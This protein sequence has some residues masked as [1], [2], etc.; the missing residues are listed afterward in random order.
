MRYGTAC[1]ILF[2][3]ASAGVNG[4]QPARGSTGPGAPNAIEIQ[5]AVVDKS[6]EPVRGLTSSDFAVEIAGR[7]RPVTGV[8]FVEF[9]VGGGSPEDERLEVSSNQ[10]E[11]RE[12]ESRAVLLLV[13]DDS[14]GPVEGEAVF[15]RLAPAVTRLFPGE[16]V[17]VAALSGRVPGV[18]FT[19]DRSRLVEALQRL[20]GG[21]AARASG[22]NL[23]VS[24][25]LEITRPTSDGRMLNE[26]VN[27][28]CA[29]LA[30]P[31]RLAQV[32]VEREACRQD[33]IKEARAQA[34]DS[35]RAVQQRIGALAG[36]LEALSTLPGPKHVLL[37]SAGVPLEPSAPVLAEVARAA[38]AGRV[39]LHALHVDRREIPQLAEVRPSPKPVDDERLLGNG[40]EALAQ[41]AG[42]AV[43]RLTGDPGPTFERV[44]RETSAM[45]RLTLKVGAGDVRGS[46]SLLVR[47]RRSGA[48]AR[49]PQ[50]VVGLEDTTGLPPRERLAHALQSPLLERGLGVRLA[51]FAFPEDAGRG[52]LLVAAEVDG[53]E[54]ELR[55]GYVVREAGGQAIETS[56]L[57]ADA[58]V[59]ERGAPPAYVFRTSMPP[60][61]Y[62]VKLAVVDMQGRLGS[63]VRA[64]TVAGPPQEG[65][66]I[67]DLLVLPDGAA[68]ERVRPSARIPQ[69]SRQ[70]SVYYELYGEGLRSPETAALL[71]EVSDAPEGPAMFSVPAAVLLEPRNR[72]VATS[73]RVNFSPAALPAGRY[74]A[75]LLVTG[76]ELR[77]VR[78]FTV[79]AAGSLLAAVLP[80]EARLALP[81]FTVSGFL[82]L[83]LLRAV[84]ARL[85]E[86][87][88]G[89]VAA[90]DAARSLEDGRWRD[91]EPAS[92]EPV[93]DATLRGLQLLSAGQPAEA[94]AAFRAALDADPEF[95]L[96][97]ALAGGAWAA[98]GRDREATRS[99]RT[100]LATGVDA[101]YLHG[102]VTTALLRQGDVNGTHEFLQELEEIGADTTRLARDAALAAAIAGDRRQAATALAAWVDTHPNDVD[103]AFLL[104]L[105]LYEL[106]TIE[107]DAA[108]SSQ[109]DARAT[110]YVEQNG[111]RAALVARWLK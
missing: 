22:M 109:F 72:R 105:A 79:T 85:S 12:S 94:E 14:F 74:F 104:V 106:K 16:A 35:A 13:D 62:T 43:H 27:R 77:A 26:T 57:G 91:V 101:P 47:V 110:R 66:A 60:G 100:S 96:A 48:F 108:A 59:I 61:A 50:R 51:A 87:A 56:E 93:V 33:I 9:R 84:S 76:S 70:A 71:L 38:A 107:K 64:V 99:W 67:G 103:A 69:G 7:A 111:P 1:L 18:S 4:Q 102:L 23:A 58:I 89:N 32:S 46:Q 19:R 6:G 73:G 82:S 15:T 92:G 8:D 25:V 3:M 34:A 29:G 95:T 45:Y 37:V 52:H 2:A 54:G 63:V 39:M 28:V 10:M 78:S 41:A 42:G 5:V 31:E 49:A 20:K 40:L 68:L 88:E 53:A 81:R 97:L 75:R 55:A 65:L 36:Q 21:Q 83:P 90:Q 98:V 11:A 30:S 86:H 24:E 80:D 17:G 44:W